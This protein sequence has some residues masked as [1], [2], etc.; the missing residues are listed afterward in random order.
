M[1]L[2]TSQSR[3]L[4]SV[5]SQNRHHLHFRPVKVDR[6]Q[7]LWLFGTVVAYT[8]NLNRQRLD[9]RL[10]TI[11]RTLEDP[12]PATFMLQVTGKGRLRTPDA[13]ASRRQR[14]GRS[15]R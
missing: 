7:R 4:E 6:V 3:Q 14:V 1:P 10:T 2:S 8:V 13:A 12:H 5:I 11:T 9:L 15:M